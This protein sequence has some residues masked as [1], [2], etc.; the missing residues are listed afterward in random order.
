MS[1]KNQLIALK[2]IQN[3]IFTIRGFQVM[4]DKDIAELYHVETK[5][6]NQAVK[7]NIERFPEP[8][9][10]QLNGVEKIELVTNCD[11]FENLKHSSINPYAVFC[12]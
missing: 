7:R 5:V 9:R 6:L 3:R 1:D 2:K 11:R 10:F 12:R 4:L 8:F